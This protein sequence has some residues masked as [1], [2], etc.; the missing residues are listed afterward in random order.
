MS[1]AE[2]VETTAS[3]SRATAETRHRSPLARRWWAV[4]GRRDQLRDDDTVAL[5]SQQRRPDR[6]APDVRLRPVDRVDDPLRVASV[7]SELLAVDA[8]ATPRRC[9]D[10][11][12]RLLGR[13]VGV[14]DRRQVGLRV[15]VE[16]EC[17]EPA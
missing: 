2:V 5:E 6:D 3:S 15:D 12:D 17:A 9:D 14:R 4:R 13:T 11:A 8:L 7:V 1:A 10:R 16:V